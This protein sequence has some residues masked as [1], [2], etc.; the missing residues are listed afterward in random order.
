[1]SER[2]RVFKTRKEQ[3]HLALSSFSSFTSTKEAAAVF[4]WLDEKV[5]IAANK[6]LFQSP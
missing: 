1:M 6:S 4:R 2:L 5:I 3:E